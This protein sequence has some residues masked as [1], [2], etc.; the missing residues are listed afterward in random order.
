[1]SPVH[2]GRRTPPELSPRS[3]H[4][5]RQC[6]SR[7]TFITTQPASQTVT[8]GQTASFSVAATGTARSA[9]SG[10]RNSHFW[11]DLYPATPPGTTSSTT[12]RSSRA[13]QQRSWKCDQQ[14]DHAH[15]ERRPRGPFDH[16]AA[17]QPDGHARPDSLLQR[18][19][20]RYRSAQLSVE[21]ERNSHSGRP[22]PATP[23]GH[24]S[25]DN[26]PLFTV[27]VSNRS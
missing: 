11:G 22:Y 18:G 24:D 21:Q 7:R 25:S 1:M 10:E 13:D 17:G 3:G 20:Y 14:R 6:G 16:D 2:R 27:L 4:P 19:C 5:H 9:I 15:G 12:G 26:G 23:P 8:A